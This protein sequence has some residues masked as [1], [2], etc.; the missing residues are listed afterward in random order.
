V[1]YKPVC[2]SSFLSPSS[3]MFKNSYPA[4]KNLTLSDT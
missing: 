2:F 1:Y 3:A 4:I